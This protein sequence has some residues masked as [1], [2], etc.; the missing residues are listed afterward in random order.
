[1]KK[2]KETR[3]SEEYT[4]IQRKI[5]RLLVPVIL[6]HLLMLGIQCNSPVKSE[7]T[8][9]I[10]SMIRY[11]ALGDSYT[12]GEGVKEAE[13][14]PNLMVTHLIENGVEI[15]IVANPS[16][17]GWTTKDLIDKELSVYRDA[18]PHF[19]TLLIGANDW[20]Q[21][22]SKD[23]F[24]ENLV[25]I[26]D[27]MLKELASNKQLV[28]VTIPDFGSTPEGPKYSN[29]RDIT[30]GLAEFNVIIHEEAAAR[31]LAVADIFA[32][33]QGMKDNAELVGSDGLHPSAKE[34]ALWE[35]II[36]PI[37]KRQLT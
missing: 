33:S 32:L 14:W 7:D 27:E 4:P 3:S 37:V 25:Y 10:Y 15:Q 2:M 29:G 18:K 28:V 21:G 26:M 16:V 23:E 8:K 11:A 17:T 22:V 24:R 19:A 30:A 35:E 1:M 6:L 36:L 9:S 34:Y 20:V 13:R 31:K 12:I 5:F